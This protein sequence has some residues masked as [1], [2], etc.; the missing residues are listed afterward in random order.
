MAEE[1]RTPDLVALTWEAFAA[2]NRRDLDATMPLYA[3]EAVLDI[4]RT[5]GVVPQGRAAI[6]RFIEDWI[7]AYEEFEY[8]PEEPVE[9]GNGVVF[10]VVS[11]KARP[12]GVTG[13]VHQREGWVCVCV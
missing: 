1:S 12:V 2:V 3:P 9:L 13:Y 8:V 5:V 11:Q 10:A 7:A 6:R 4:S